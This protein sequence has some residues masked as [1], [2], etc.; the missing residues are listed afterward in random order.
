MT[1]SRDDARFNLSISSDEVC[2]LDG[3]SRFVATFRSCEDSRLRRFLTESSMI[4]SVPWIFLGKMESLEGV[5]L[6][7]CVSLSMDDLRES[8]RDDLSRL[9]KFMMSLLTEDALLGIASSSLRRGTI[10]SDLS[11]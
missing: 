3:G 7:I 11:K 4:P 9:S 2:F 8:L 5:F 1:F 6:A 10:I